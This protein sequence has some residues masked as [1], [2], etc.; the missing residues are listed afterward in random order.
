MA[1]YQHSK[2]RYRSKLSVYCGRPDL[3]RLI[4]VLFLCLIFF[5]ISTSF[6]KL[7]GVRVELPQVEQAS[8]TSLERHLISIAGDTKQ[9]KIYYN[10]Q[11]LLLGGLAEL[12]LPEGQMVIICADK[13]ASVD[14]LTNVMVILEKKRLKSFIMVSDEEAHEEVI[15]E[16]E[17][18]D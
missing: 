12:N 10:D 2:R 14:L 7:K 18:Q 11:E 17:V 5:I 16:T 3:T 13:N 9:Y 4:D 15:F 8:S 1:S 6:V